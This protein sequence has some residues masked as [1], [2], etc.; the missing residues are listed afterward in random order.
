MNVVRPKHWWFWAIIALAL[1]LGIALSGLFTWSRLN[2]WDEEIDIL[3]GRMRYTRYLFYCRV[4]ERVASTELSEALRPTDFDPDAPKWRK[5]N[6]FSPGVHHSP[7]YAYHAASAQTRTL[8]MYWR[9]GQFTPAARRESALRLLADYQ[10]GKGYFV[11]EPYLRQLSDL[12][13]E[14]FVQKPVIPVEMTDLPK[15]RTGSD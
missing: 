2:C 8:V 5:V 9:M 7:H 10:R 12:V 4:S 1:G 13:G 11:A 3:S 14:R 15:V 6:T